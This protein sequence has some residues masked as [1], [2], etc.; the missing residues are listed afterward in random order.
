MGAEHAITKTAGQYFP[1][2]ECLGFSKRESRMGVRLRFSSMRGTSCML[3]ELLQEG[4]QN[5]SKICEALTAI[6]GQMP[7]GKKFHSAERGPNWSTDVA[8]SSNSAFHP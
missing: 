3:Y 6:I 5:E 8:R 4:A 2:L 7:R 1:M